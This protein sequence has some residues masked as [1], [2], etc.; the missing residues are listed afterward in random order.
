MEFTLLGSVLVAL[1]ALYAGLWLMG[2]RDPTFCVRDVWDLALA[3]AISGLI[4]GRVVAMVKGGVNPITH[5]GDF[6]L[7]RAGVDTVGAS[8]G[9]LAAV[10]FL[11]RDRLP[12]LLDQLAPAALFG[13]GGW[14]AGCLVRSTCL[15]AP[16]DLPWTW[17]V[18]GSSITRH[19]V[20]IYAAL[21]FGLA[22]WFV[23]RWRNKPWLA[24]SLGLS[25][26]GL[27]RLAVFPIQP[28]LSSAVVWWYLS[29]A[30]V[31]LIA[32]SYTARPLS[33]WRNW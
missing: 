29:A 31:G 16:S 20:E 11:Q 27:I 4:V 13:L 14:H 21:A 12:G 28:S 19:P 17:S 5:P 8:V 10:A 25:L 32:A 18:E 2:R 7:V 22:G 30:V 33:E 15:G 26:A 9:A 6:I 23:F 24:V 1:F 3:G